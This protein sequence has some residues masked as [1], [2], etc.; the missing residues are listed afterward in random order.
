MWVLALTF[1]VTL[2]A[3]T[4]SSAGGGGGG[5]VTTPYLIFIGLTPQ[6]A[7][8]TGKMSGLGIGVGS[9][10]AFKGKGLIRKRLSIALIV[11]TIITSAIA[12]WLLPKID[13]VIFTKIIGVLL[14]VL[15]PTLFIDKAGLKPG[16]RSKAYIR[17]GFVVYA[18]VAIAQAM[19]GTGLAL[20]LTLVLM[21][22]F[23]LTA[24]Q[25]NATK[26]LGQLVQMVIMFTLLALQGLVVWS[27][28]AAGLLGSFIGGHLGSKLAIKK[29]NQFV[30]IILAVTMV[31]SGVALLLVE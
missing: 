9:L 24:L 7:I 28:G 20:F 31:V 15:A 6:Q 4:F 17:V 27:H 21:Y 12:A 10:W 13:E 30:K 16:P 18:L 11:L 23:G 3:S 26:R 19:I 22:L 1:F 5:F 8:A 25:A 2:I 29:G 14:I